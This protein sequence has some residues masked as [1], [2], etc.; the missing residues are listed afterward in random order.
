MRR[1]VG[2]SALTLSC[3]SA[4]AL[5][6]QIEWQHCSLTKDV[7]F[8]PYVAPSDNELVDVQADNAQLVSEGT[9][10]FSGSVVVTRGGR[11]LTADRATYN[12][13]SGTI[14]ARD[15]MR[16]RDNEIVLD[17]EQ[18]EWSMTTDE[19]ALVDAEYQLRQNHAR[20]QA[21]YVLK[22]AAASTRL[23]HASYTTC[24]KGDNFWDLQAT[25]INL[26]H[27]E[28]V[29]EARDVVIRIKDVPVM[30]T[31]RITFP[32]NDERKSGF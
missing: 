2:F 8:L 29:G 26:D 23:Q 24:A 14:T 6:D 15:N 10:V 22:Q 11:E 13:A 12:R 30:Y 7:N 18:A 27:E 31:P 21:G 1:L 25:T 16:L 32:L 17:A 28:G 19:G 4:S 20:G 9:S 3:L 5:A